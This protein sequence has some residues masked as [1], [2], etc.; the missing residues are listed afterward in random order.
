MTTSSVRAMACCLALSFCAAAPV[1]AQESAAAA[2][3]RDHDAE[4][5]A[6][7]MAYED[8]QQAWGKEART[9]TADQRDALLARRDA[10]DSDYLGRF[11]ALADAAR[12]TDAGA[13]AT[14]WVVQIALNASGTE[15]RARIGLAL[16]SIATDYVGSEA[17]A[18]LPASLV[19]VTDEDLTA[20]VDDVLETLLEKSPHAAVRASSLHA[21]AQR[22]MNRSRSAPVGAD[23]LQAKARA[24]FVRLHEDYGDRMSPWGRSYGDLAAGT[25]FEL[26]HLQVGMAPPD[27]EAV[28]Q[29][30]A[31]FKLSDYKGKVVVLDF[32]GYW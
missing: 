5:Q 8:A 1:R 11:A 28:D 26:D 10:I 27:F 21:L 29:D 7:A 22:A 4:L 2:P 13:K 32:W 17:I 20:K 15:A 30:G 25:L 16:D 18:D 31:A 3:V 23:A 6:L 12:G 9:A 19:Y 14:A 24:L